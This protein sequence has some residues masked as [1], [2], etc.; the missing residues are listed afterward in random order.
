VLTCFVFLARFRA[1][2]G[3]DISGKRRQRTQLV[4]FSITAAA[5]ESVGHRESLSRRSA[6]GKGGKG[7]R[8]SDAMNRATS[9]STSA[10]PASSL[11]RL[12]SRL[13]GTPKRSE[14]RVSHRK[15]TTAHPSNR[16]SSQLS[17]FHQ[18]FAH[19]TNLAR[20]P[21]T[22]NRVETRLSYRK[23]TTVTCSTRDETRLS[24]RAESDGLS[25]AKLDPRHL[26]VT[27]YQ[28]LHRRA[29]VSEKSARGVSLG[30]GTFL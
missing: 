5:T 7:G 19:H 25:A 11:Q 21:E 17:N 27:T 23:Q 15:Q 14:T 3:Q 20:L 2:G 4:C 22:L 6:Q 9:V 12:A 26:P 28:S 16:Y 13:I 24:F 30:R 10:F 29:R 18:L 8:G 1:A